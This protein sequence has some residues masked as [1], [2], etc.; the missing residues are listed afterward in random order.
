[1][2][3]FQYILSS[4]LGGQALK[5]ELG[6]DKVDEILTAAAKKFKGFTGRDIAKTMAALQAAVY[7]S[8]K[9]VLDE[10]LLNQVIDYRLAEFKKK[11]KL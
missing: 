9:G 6:S 2:F 3:W 11:D 8:V 1:M 7:G 10:A 4:T 5:V